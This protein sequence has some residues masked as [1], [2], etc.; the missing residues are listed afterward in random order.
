MHVCIQSSEINVAMQAAEISASVEIDTF[1]L[2]EMNSTVDAVLLS[3]RWGG[4]LGHMDWNSHN[5][6]NVPV[7]SSA[8]TQVFLS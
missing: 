1:S 4:K 6:V 2:K 5:H 3:R 8:L 7:V